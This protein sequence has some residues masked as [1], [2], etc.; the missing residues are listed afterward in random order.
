MKVDANESNNNFGHLAAKFENH[1]L[2]IW[3]KNRKNIFSSKTFP[4]IQI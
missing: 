2:T 4:L 3:I 1:N